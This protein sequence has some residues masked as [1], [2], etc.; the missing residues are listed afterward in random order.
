[1]PMTIDPQNPGT[2]SELSLLTSQDLYL[3][4]EGR[5]Y[6]SYNKLGAHLM[7]E[8]GTC[9]SVWAPNAREVSVI[10]SFN[11]WDEHAHRLE[12]RGN[13]GI[14]EGFVPEAKKGDLYKFRIRSHQNEYVIDKA[15]PFGVW[16][17]EP[18]RTASVVWDLGMCG[19]TTS[20]CKSAMPG[21][22]CR[23]RCQFTSCTWDHGCVCLKRAIGRCPIANW[24]PASPIT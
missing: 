15:D 18:P 22:L 2:S 9:F 7:E 10:G 6:R 4:N 21:T 24:R 5:H 12:P 17:Q 20:G 19:R 14:W 23:H 11:Q 3:F 16:H 13:S 8:R 1:M